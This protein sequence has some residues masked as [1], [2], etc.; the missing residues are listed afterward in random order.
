MSGLPNINISFTSAAA[1]TAAR[2]QRGVVAVILKDA[3]EAGAHVMT[4]K[5]QIPSGLSA[6]NQTYLEQAFLGYVTPPRKVIAYVLATDAEDYTAAL[7]YFATQQFDYIV[8]APDCTG[9]QAT[10]IAAWIATQRAAAAIY[11]AVLPDTAADSE[12]IVNFTSDGMTDGT[13]TWTTAQFCARI[14][15]IIA[16]TPITIACTYA[17]VAELT[18]ITRLTKS[19][20]DA[21]VAAG[22]LILMYDGEKVKVARGVN[23]LTTTTATKGESFKK[24]K[25]VEAVD[26]IR[27][28]ITTTVQDTYIG[29]Y[30]NSYD[31]KCVLVA[32]IQDYFLTLERAG[33]LEEGRS[34]V[35]IDVDAQE[36]YLQDQDVDT[37]ALSEQQI[38]EYDTNDQVF[39]KATISILD[40]IEDIALAITM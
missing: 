7:S 11:K 27:K 39:L 9:A 16:G 19:E 35:G 8:G 20:M 12:A 37:S 22:K 13:T 2:S 24:I 1:A 34:S 40:A 23:S 32:A 25:V 38:K 36:A 14:A 18:D 17:P 21:A 15:G 3:A 31:N 5:S 28:D 33:V 4:S 10:A 26:M 30:A 29:K 6:G